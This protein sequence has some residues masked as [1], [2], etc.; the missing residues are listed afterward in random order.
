MNAPLPAHVCKPA[1]KPRKPEPCR[2]KAYPF[3]HREFS[4]KCFADSWGPYCGDCGRP[5]NTTTVDEGIGAY[6]YWGQKGVDVRLA[7]VSTCCE[8]PVFS[9]AALTVEAD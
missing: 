9:D 3:P 8:A 1:L 4:G 6:E 7:T 2:C 5:C